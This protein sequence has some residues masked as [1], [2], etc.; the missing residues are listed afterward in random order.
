MEW[1]RSW[2]AH[3]V[4]ASERGS[5]S[6]QESLEGHLVGKL[7]G[8]N[9]RR[10]RIPPPSL[11]HSVYLEAVVFTSRKKKIEFFGIF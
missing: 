5:C 11:T 4:R 8:K 10:I 1:G 6:A 3:R 9:V 2:S 7:E